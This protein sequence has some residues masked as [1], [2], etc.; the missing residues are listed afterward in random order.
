MGQFDVASVVLNKYTEKF[1]KKKI[2]TSL[3]LDRI[4]RHNTFVRVN[5]NMKLH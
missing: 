5:Y 1:N 4:R 3:V 2:M